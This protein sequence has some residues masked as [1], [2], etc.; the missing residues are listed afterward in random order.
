MGSVEHNYR[1]CWKSPTL[2]PAGNWISECQ[3]NY[4]ARPLSSSS[5]VHLVAAQL[6]MGEYYGFDRFL[7]LLPPAEEGCAH[8]L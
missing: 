4:G 5:E 1:F 8:A 7:M 2:L 3:L 6:A